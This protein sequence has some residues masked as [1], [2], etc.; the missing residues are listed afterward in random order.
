M[1]TASLNYHIPQK[2]KKGASLEYLQIFLSSFFEE[3]TKKE[4]KYK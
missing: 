3:E 1:I 2:V 4:T